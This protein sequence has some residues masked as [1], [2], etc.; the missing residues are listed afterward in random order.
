MEY[1]QNDLV[2][3]FL[4]IYYARNSWKII[5]DELIDLKKKLTN[6]YADFIIF[7]SEEKGENIRVAISSIPSNT[8]KVKYA[9]ENFNIFVETNPSKSSFL[10]PYGKTLWKNYE[11]N[12]VIW[13][14]FIKME[15]YKDVGNFEQAN[16]NLLLE[17][18]HNDYSPDNFLTAGL[19]LYL[20]ILKQFAIRQVRI[21]EIIIE[22]IDLLSEKFENFELQK[23]ID[24][25]ILAYQVDIKSVFITLDDFW[26]EL[27]NSPLFIEWSSCVDIAIENKIDFKYLSQIILN[28]L[29]LGASHNMLILVFLYKWSLSRYCELKNTNEFSCLFIVNN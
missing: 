5:V 13:N 22:T 2:W 12:S 7:F 4:S 24:D 23:M 3:N 19:Y 18:L 26:H 27:N 16:S 21:N 11:N 17:L 14:S 25:I 9:I 6:E 1:N 8:T 10:F 20:K 28:H 29:G 15:S